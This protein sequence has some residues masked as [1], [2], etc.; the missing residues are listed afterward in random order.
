MK[1]LAARERRWR[2]GFFVVATV[3]VAYLLLDLL[4]RAVAQ[5]GQIVAV[6]FLAWLL[7]FVLAP[8]VA[9]LTSRTRLSRGA[10]V[11]IVY[12]VALLVGGVLLF[13]TVSAAGAQVGDLATHFPETRTRII[14]TLQG[15]QSSVSFGRFQPDLVTLF[16]DVQRQAGGLGSSIAQAIPSVTVSVIGA[17][18]LV[19]ILSLYMVADSATILAKLNRVV[20]Q[21]YE[22]QAAIFERTVARA[23]G[24]FLRAQVLL[25]AI[26]AVLTVGVVIGAGL[27]YG[28][29]IT[30][31]ATLAMLIPFF[32]PPLAL[33]P[34][35]LATAIYRPEWILP[36][37]LLLLVTQTV[38]V[39]YLQPRLMRDALGMHPILVLVGLLVGAQIAGLWGALF[40]IPVIAVANVF[41]NYFVN[42]RTIEETLEVDT[43]TILDE[44]R[45]EAPD[46][47]AEQLVALAAERA[48]AAHEEA[49]A[50]GEP[51]LGTVS[52]ELRASAEEI[53]RA[54][55]DQTG[56]AREMKSA[57]SAVQDSARS[58]QESTGELKSAVEGLGG[59]RPPGERS[60]DPAQ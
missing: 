16:N 34:P 58:L 43:E 55:S 31:A 52:G 11:G 57:S 53:R 47:T 45:D 9:L 59:E 6:V 24:G 14:A 36:V 4:G 8:L 33:L 17:L 5:F 49:R 39:N 1:T 15:W 27:P 12:G 26:Q 13:Y 19:L 29:L 40:G 20:P 18:V 21:R 60:G 22:E 37:G 28:V 56:A 51:A 41:F 23:F 42:L 38:I 50:T 35:V 48:E 46:A 54:A 32:G 44:V 10:A 7:A 25:A 2:I 3:Y 30:L